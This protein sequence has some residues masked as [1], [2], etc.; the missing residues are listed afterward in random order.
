[1]FRILSVRIVSCVEE[2]VNFNAC[3]DFAES[4]GIVCCVL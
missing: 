2:E 4:E 3:V 1:M